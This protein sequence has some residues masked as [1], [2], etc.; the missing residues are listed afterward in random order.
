MFF[1]CFAL[2]LSF[3]FGVYS[4]FCPTPVSIICSTGAEI[5]MCYCVQPLTIQH[6]L[7]QRHGRGY[8]QFLS[9][10]ERNSFHRIKAEGLP[11]LPFSQRR[12]GLWG[13]H[14]NKSNWFFARRHYSVQAIVLGWWVERERERKVSP[15]SRSIF[16]TPFRCPVFFKRAIRD[17]PWLCMSQE[18]LGVRHQVKNWE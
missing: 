9:K 18:D 13:S 7:E 11:Q 10:M 14:P 12:S 17:Q 6:W 5:L 15:A 2:A 16:D 3:P 1:D 8:F 4:A